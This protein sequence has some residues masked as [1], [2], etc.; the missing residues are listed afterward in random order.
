[1]HVQLHH[2]CFHPQLSVNVLWAAQMWARLASGTYQVKQSWNSG[3]A[4]SV[5]GREMQAGVSVPRER[6]PCPKWRA[7]RQEKSCSLSHLLVCHPS[8]LLCSCRFI[9]GVVVNSAGGVTHSCLFV[10]VFLS[11]ILPE[12]GILLGEILPGILSSC[13]CWR[14]RLQPFCQ[15]RNSWSD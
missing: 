10:K 15:F 5:N 3:E 8:L 1:M 12:G 11:L 9:E 2:T 6:L 13:F 14:I 4:T 7:S